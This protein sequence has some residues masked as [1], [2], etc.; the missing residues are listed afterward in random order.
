ML[1]E[2][3]NELEKKYPRSYFNYS[4]DNWI[5]FL[6]S[7]SLVIEEN[8]FLKITD[9]GRAFLTYIIYQRGYDITLKTL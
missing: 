1:L 6:T 2:N 8:S 5:A 9:N 7:N 4:F 3:Y